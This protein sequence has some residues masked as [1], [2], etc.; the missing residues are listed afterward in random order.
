MEARKRLL[1]LHTDRQ[2]GGRA[3]AQARRQADRDDELIRASLAHRK[4]GDKRMAIPAM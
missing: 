4:V 1:L 2:A 3:G